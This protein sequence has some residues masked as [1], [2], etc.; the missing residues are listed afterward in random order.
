[1]GIKIRG[2][3]LENLRFDYANAPKVGGGGK[4]LNLFFKNIVKFN[5][6]LHPLQKITQKFK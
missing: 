3:D 4:K 6:H 2:I 5:L 1:M